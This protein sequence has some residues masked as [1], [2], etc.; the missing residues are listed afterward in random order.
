[1]KYILSVAF[2]S[3]A[4]LVLLVFLTGS[5]VENIILSEISN[6]DNYF[7]KLDNLDIQVFRNILF[8]PSEEPE[9]F[10][11]VHFEAAELAALTEETEDAEEIE[12]E[13]IDEPVEVIEATEN[14]PIIISVFDYKTG[15]TYSINLEDYLAGVVFSEMPAS[16]EFEALKAQAVAARSFCVYKILY[17]HDEERAYHNGADICNDYRHCKDY[18][19]RE[20]AV[21]KYGEIAKF[22]EKIKSA[23]F[24]T[25]GEIIT[26]DFEP[27]IAVFH[28]MSGNET[29]SAENVWGNDVPYLI[30]V[31]SEEI[32]NTDNI[33]NYKTESKFTTD[34]FKSI[35]ING[36]YN[37][38]FSINYTQWLENIEINSSGR[39]DY[40]LICGEKI[41]GVHL[42]ELF[43]LRST[44]FTIELTQSGEF[45]F[46]VKGY[47]HGV[48]MS[49]YGA[50]LMALNG[51]N[52]IEILKWYYTGIEINPADM[53]FAP[54]T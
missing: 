26:Y 21:E 35:L 38:D 37:A 14:S 27:A 46:T 13:V 52:Y 39:V 25:A 51:K 17:S 49:Q 4:G 29:E 16:F 10:E 8:K 36:G 2:I 31:Q 7:D 30:S 24:E 23:V 53:F 22:W 40:A 54:L 44:D 5:G 48:G 33:K 3:F 11:S 9:I 42:R 19:S 47:G 15:E 12:K 18:M 28:A 6:R 1:M 34:E 43:S 20:A 50:N 41:P 45:I 32:N